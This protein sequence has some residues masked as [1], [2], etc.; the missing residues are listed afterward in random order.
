ML[1]SRFATGISGADHEIWQS[2]APGVLCHVT[3]PLEKQTHFRIWLG[4]GDLNQ[5]A[6][7]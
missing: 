3:V 7:N 1:V 6:P 2:L 5:H 4:T